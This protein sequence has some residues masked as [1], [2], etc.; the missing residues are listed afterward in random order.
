M[1]DHENVRSE[2]A[3]HQYFDRTS[4]GLPNY[5]Q[6]LLKENPIAIALETMGGRLNRSSRVWPPTGDWQGPRPQQAF[7]SGEY[8]V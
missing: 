1:V 6:E 3:G 2:M 4:R 5:S 7:P 8:G